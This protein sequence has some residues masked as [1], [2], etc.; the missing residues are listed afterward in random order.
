[1]RVGGDGFAHEDGRRGSVHP[2]RRTARFCEGSSA[3]RSRDRVTRWEWRELGRS[4]HT[5]QH[6]VLDLCLIR[7]GGR[8]SYAA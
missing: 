7:F 6:I 1:M 4:R 5:R 8:F 3:K 2:L